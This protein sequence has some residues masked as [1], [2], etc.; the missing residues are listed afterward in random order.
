MR[1]IPL[2]CF[3]VLAATALAVVSVAPAA[4]QTMPSEPCGGNSAFRTR[5]EGSNAPPR[6]TAPAAFRE[7]RWFSFGLVRDRSLGG[8]WARAMGLAD[9]AD[10]PARRRSIR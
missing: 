10:V 6:V 1:W 2:L 7:F 9:P 3:V 5:T 4:A 8:L